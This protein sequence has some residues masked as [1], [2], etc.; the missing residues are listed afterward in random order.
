M[1]ISDAR[2]RWRRSRRCGSASR[3]PQVR[4]LQFPSSAMK[5][6]TASAVIARPRVRIEH[7]V[8]VVTLVERRLAAEPEGGIALLECGLAVA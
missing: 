6:E 4:N 2:G 1:L 8:G 5:T 7:L 3:D